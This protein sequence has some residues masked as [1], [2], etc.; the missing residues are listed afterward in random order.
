MC[1]GVCKNKVLHRRDDMGRLVEVTTKNKKYH[2]VKIQ[3]FE[4][5]EKIY[6]HQQKKRIY[7]LGLVER[8]LSSKNIIQ[9]YTL[10]NKIIIH[11]ND[12]YYLFSLKITP[13]SH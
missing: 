3:N 6:D 12:E 9:M 7:L 1:I 8:Y 11:N 2:M 4:V 13:V 5:E 10:N